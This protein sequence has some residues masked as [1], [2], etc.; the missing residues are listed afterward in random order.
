MRYRKCKQCGDSLGRVSYGSLCKTCSA[1]NHQ[2]RRLTRKHI[3]RARRFGV[4]YEPVQ[5]KRVYER[6]QW[7][8]G[9]CTKRVDNRLKYPHP[10]S[11]SLDHVAPLSRGGG[12]TYANTQLAHLPCNLAKGDRGAGEQLALVG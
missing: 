3:Q 12:H 11:A 9:I 10:M 2:A 8:C 6:D 1:A 7:H 4:Q 5:A